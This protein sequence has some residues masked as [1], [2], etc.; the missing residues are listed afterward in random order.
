[1][2]SNSRLDNFNETNI[3]AKPTDYFNSFYLTEEKV[4]SRIMKSGLIK[5]V[6]WAQEY[7]VKLSKLLKLPYTTESTV[8]VHDCLSDFIT[9][10]KRKIKKIKPPADLGDEHKE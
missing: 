9:R 6:V 3:H 8:G 4:H 10:H 7:R 5:T 2:V 1:M